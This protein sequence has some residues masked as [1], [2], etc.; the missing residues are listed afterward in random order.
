MPENV[1][2]IAVLEEVGSASTRHFA[3]YR[4]K[5]LPISGREPFIGDIIHIV[6]IEPKLAIV[7]VM[8]TNVLQM[9]AS[10]LCN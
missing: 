1:L 9:Q 6:G 5:A 3:G 2:F 4:V 10:D 7:L 8:Y